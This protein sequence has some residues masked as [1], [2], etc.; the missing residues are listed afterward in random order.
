M[1][2]EVVTGIHSVMA[3]DALASS[4]PMT[5]DV[6]SRQE[7]SSIFDGVTYQKVSEWLM[8]W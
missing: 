3:S 1:D 6:E 7:V 8:D 2:I 5:A 4:H